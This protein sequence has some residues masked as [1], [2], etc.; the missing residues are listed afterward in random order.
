MTTIDIYKKHYEEVCSWHVDEYDKYEW[1]AN[2]IF[3]LCTY[4]AAMDEKLVKDILEVCK[5]II[6]RTNYEYIRDDNNYTKYIL[7]CQLLYHFHWLTWGTSIR[8]AWFEE[9]CH[10]AQK[11]ILKGEKLSR[12]N[13]DTKEREDCDIERVQFTCDNLRALIKFMEAEN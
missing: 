11:D 13:P 9:L 5:V 10:C 2:Y 3:G 1:A 8:G 12:Y 6:D 4:D 7:V